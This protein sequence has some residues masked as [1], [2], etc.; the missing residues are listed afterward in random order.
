MNLDKLDNKYQITN[1]INYFQMINE[2][3]DYNSLIKILNKK[4]DLFIAINGKII[5]VKN[6]YV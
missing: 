2:I 3:N 5:N 6:F 4:D 1:N